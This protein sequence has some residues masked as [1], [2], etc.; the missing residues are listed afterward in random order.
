MDVI[1]C[2]VHLWQVNHTRQLDELLSYTSYKVNRT[3]VECVGNPWISVV[4]EF[5]NQ[6]LLW[7][8]VA[9]ICR[10]ATSLLFL[11]VRFPTIK[12]RDCYRFDSIL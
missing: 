10:L 3:S 12:L 2:C 7:G 9:A 5:D 8:T 4:V 11:L 6:L 1:S